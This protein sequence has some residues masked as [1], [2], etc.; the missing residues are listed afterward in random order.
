MPDYLFDHVHLTSPDPLRTAEFYEKMLGARR[1]GIRELTDG[2]SLVDLVLN[3]SP[4][5]VS[6]P[7]AQ[8]LAPSTSQPGCGLEHFGLRTDNI[9]V[10]VD[11]LKAKGVE[12]VQEISVRPKVKV[13]FF[14]D[15]DGV[16]IELV[17]R[18]T[19]HGKHDRSEYMD[20]MSRVGT[21][22]SSQPLNL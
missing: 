20:R 22:F 4:I 12:F 9:E 7:R 15:A 14:L 17:E 16:L 10:A 5:K 3:G 19:G 8:P 18:S 11:E 21:P 13:S 1:I 2:R 6:H